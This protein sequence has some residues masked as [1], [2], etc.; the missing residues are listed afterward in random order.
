MRQQLIDWIESGAIA[1]DRVPQALEVS[2]LYP[3]GA[4]W[5]RFLDRLM[6]VLG[7]LA[8]T[9]A[10]IVAWIFVLSRAIAPALNARLS[11]LRTPRGTAKE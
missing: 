5:R 8:L 1:R 2:G 10:V 4:G 11:R 3:D 7:V 6:L 9:C